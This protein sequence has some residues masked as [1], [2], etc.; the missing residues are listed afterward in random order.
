MRIIEC[1]LLKDKL[2]NFFLT[3]YYKEIGTKHDRPQSKE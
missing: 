2:G 1:A 3:L